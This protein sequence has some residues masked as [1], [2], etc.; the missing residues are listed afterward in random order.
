ML[1]DQKSIVNTVP[2]PAG[3]D[4]AQPN[5]QI[6][7]QM[8]IATYRLNLPRGQFSGNTKYTFVKPS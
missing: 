4:N 2:G 8:D 5:R 6:N 7:K 3:V 1:F